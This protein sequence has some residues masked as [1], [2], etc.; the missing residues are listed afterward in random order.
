MMKMK[1]KKE[2]T[3]HVTVLVTCLAHTFVDINNQLL[4][5]KSL[6]VN[7]HVRVIKIS[8]CYRLRD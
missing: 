1:K 8:L 6:V 7:P 3:P 4:A 5:C 2:T